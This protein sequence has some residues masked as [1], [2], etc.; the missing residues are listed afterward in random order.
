MR[1]SANWG[2]P[3]KPR[4]QP[5]SHIHVVQR[6]KSTSTRTP[7]NYKPAYRSF[8]RL[9]SLDQQAKS[10]E[11]YYITAKLARRLQ[12]L[13][14]RNIQTVAKL[15][16][17]QRAEFERAKVATNKAIKIAATSRK[18]I[19]TYEEALPSSEFEMMQDPKTLSQVFE[20]FGECDF[21]GQNMKRWGKLGPYSFLVAFEAGNTD[22]AIKTALIEMQKGDIRR[23]TA[24]AV[25][26]TALNMTDWRAMTVWL[27]RATQMTHTKAGAR[28]NY[29][30]AKK[31]DSMLEAGD[32]IINRMP[33]L[34]QYVPPWKFVFRA[35][36][37]Y[38]WHLQNDNPDSPECK[39]VEADLDNALQAGVNDWKDPEAAEE[40]LRQKRTVG[41]KD[42][43]DIP[44]GTE[45]WVSLTTQSAMAGSILHSYRLAVHL[46]REEGWFWWRLDSD[47]KKVDPNTSFGGW[48]LNLSAA[49][50]THNANDMASRYTAMILLLREH[51]Y[52][53]MAYAWI[54]NARKDL[55]TCPKG[56]EM[57]LGIDQLKFLKD[58][59]DDDDS[60][61]KI[62]SYDYLD[63]EYARSL[64]KER[65]DG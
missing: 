54:E 40:L 11:D 47:K 36:D 33:I 14:F 63:K 38:L 20:A 37:H 7:R 9:K 12:N 25:R 51:D 30:M 49:L 50:A 45:R 10:S 55:E 58:N 65:I 8:D 4:C 56:P 16:N 57:Q 62:K 19:E 60:M 61:R 46:L 17:H 13:G 18:W 6:L 53:D 48:W 32:R 23:E 1:L 52:K 39:Q 35:A 26:E 31:L 59:W 2:I 64:A 24:E 43:S 22:A 29:L 21:H 34:E 5:F 44:E 28:D 27:Y 42:V 3:S 15:F 41:G